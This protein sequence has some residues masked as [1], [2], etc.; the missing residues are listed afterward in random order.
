MED[1]NRPLEN[2][3]NQP[4]QEGGGYEQWTRPS[5]R[6]HYTVIAVIVML[7]VAALF[8]RSQWLRIHDVEVIGLVD[9]S[10]EQVLQLA[11]IDGSST[12]FNLNE[13]KISQRINNNRYLE[14]VS[15]EKFWPDGL[16][17][18]VNERRKTANFLYVG[19]QYILAEDGMV[20]ES[21]TNI[22]LD[23]GCIK[24]TGLNVHGIRVGAK[25]VCQQPLQME[26]M[27][28]VLDEL[29][30]QGV[31]A[32]MA[33]LNLSSLESIYLVTMDGYTAN[34]GNGEELRAKIGTVRA[35]ADELRRR[36]LQGGMIEATVPGQASYR[37]IQ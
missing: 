35:V 16:V 23:N 28:N 15:M 33:E 19:V 1:S 21:S 3:E 25:V 7:T 26:T 11:G 13:K 24:V 37:P 10:K 27:Q 36:G 31:L 32:D 22:A 34:I 14:F 8:A 9:M 2:M 30:M 18:T 20:L 4:A 5:R 29:R 17:L 12:Y 6:G